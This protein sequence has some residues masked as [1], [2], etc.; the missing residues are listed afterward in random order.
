MHNAAVCADTCP[1]V[2]VQSLHDAIKTGCTT[3]VLRALAPRPAPA[4]PTS[5]GR[6][7]A[8]VVRASNE[9]KEVQYNKEFGYSRKDVILIGVGLIALGYALYYGLQA[10]GM[11]PGMA[12][13][14]V[15]LIIFMGICVGWVSTYI[16]RVATK[17]R[18]R[19]GVVR[20]LAGPAGIGGGVGRAGVAHRVVPGVRMWCARGAGCP[21]CIR[22][23]NRRAVMHAVW[24][25]KAL[26]QMQMQGQSPAPSGLGCTATHWLSSPAPR[27]RRAVGQQRESALREPGTFDSSMNAAMDG[28]G[29]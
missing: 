25:H 3:R 24:R 23:S 15:Q 17:V 26:T 1:V 8:L 20:G 13:N 7:V 4:G 16:F 2:H 14:W 10:G 27:E 28:A 18:C 9:E 21:G 22:V 6:A 12:G 5:S 11:E 19:A 29:R